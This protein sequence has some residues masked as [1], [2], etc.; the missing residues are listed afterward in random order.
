[1]HTNLLSHS[2]KKE[3]EDALRPN[4]FQQFIRRRT[5]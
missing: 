5:C 4:G 2:P 1:M 3:T